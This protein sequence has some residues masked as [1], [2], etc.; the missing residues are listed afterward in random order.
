MEVK[1]KVHQVLKVESGTSKAGKEWK[2]Q[3]FV[4]DTGDQYNPYLCISAFGDDKLEIV[5]G[6]KVGQDVNVFF[7][8]SSKEYNEKWY[9]S[10]D[11]WKIG[12]SNAITVSDYVGNE[13][14]SPD[15]GDLPF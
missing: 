7:N 5:A 6:L 2:K 9:H 1:G 8:L 11:F 10:V 14:I 3:S 15:E 12:D 4:I 13:P